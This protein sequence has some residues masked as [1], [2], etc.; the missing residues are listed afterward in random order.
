MDNQHY[1]D[2]ARPAGIDSILDTRSAGVAD[3]DGDGRLDVAVTN[4]AERAQFYL[5]QLD[6][7]NNWLAL[8]LRGTRGNTD[9]VG[10]YVRLTVDDVTLTRRV[11]SGGGYSSQDQRILHFGLGDAEVV[12]GL[13]II[14]SDGS[15]E[16]FDAEMLAGL[17]LNSRHLIIQ[18]RGKLEP[19]QRQSRL[20][21]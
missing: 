14:W 5:N 1:V 21:K 4:N 18:G 11:E 19:D 17:T 8:S 10:A 2:T 15:R 7:G 9:A 6:N 16:F 20:V 12:K 13:E 3:F